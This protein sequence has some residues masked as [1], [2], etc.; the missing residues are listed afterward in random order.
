MVLPD[1]WLAV[2]V[3]L[4]CATQWRVSRGVILGLDY[5]GC[6]SVEAG[7][8]HWWADVFEG[9]QVMEREAL[10]CETEKRQ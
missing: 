3:F 2:D 10:K 5:P 1:N 7:L 8:G 9:L 4:S 6:E